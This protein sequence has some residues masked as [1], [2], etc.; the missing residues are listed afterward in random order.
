[1]TPE[2]A[3]GIYY[4]ALARAY[5]KRRDEWKSPIVQNDAQLE[6]WRAVIVSVENALSLELMDA[7]VFSGEKGKH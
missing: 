4:D 6:A 3:Q 1:M 2:Q 7:G 5:M